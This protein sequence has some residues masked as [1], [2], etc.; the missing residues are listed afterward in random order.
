M[1]TAQAFSD[2]AHGA[3]QP[4]WVLCQLDL[5]EDA[6]TANTLQGRWNEGN[7][8]GSLAHP[9][10]LKA[11]NKLIGR[12]MAGAHAEDRAQDLRK[13][14]EHLEVARLR[15]DPRRQRGVG[16]VGHPF[17]DD[18]ANASV[19]RITC[20]LSV[21]PTYS[22]TDWSG[23]LALPDARMYVSVPSRL[24]LS[25]LSTACMVLLLRAGSSTCTTDQEVGVPDVVGR[26]AQVI[27]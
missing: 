3:H 1:A 5:V 13:E 17:N 24:I 26:A 12:D 16:K 18:V 10:R 11:S 20:L 23:W 21:M 25:M 2:G 7:S 19:G 8:A 27:R 14:R 9:Q 6:I 22:T 15:L 4:F